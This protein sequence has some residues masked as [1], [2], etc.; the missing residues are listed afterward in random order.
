MLQ[1]DYAAILVAYLGLGFVALAAFGGLP[2]DIPG[3][4]P[5]ACPP[6]SIAPEPHPCPIQHLI[7][8]NFQ[9]FSFRPIGY[10]LALYPVFAL[11]TN[12]PLI[13]ITLRNNL[14]SII[15]ALV[16]SLSG[17]LRRWHCT[18]LTALP[19][20]TIAFFYRDVDALA[21]FTG[22]V[23]KRRHILSRITVKPADS[24][25]P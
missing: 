19:A 10:Y 25:H 22:G 15:P 1:V 23:D 21:G 4:P 5:G 7:T 17:K 24:W 11:T 20:Y 3:N 9:S 18:L 13:A 14:M 8:Q 16:P 6:T 2:A 12:F